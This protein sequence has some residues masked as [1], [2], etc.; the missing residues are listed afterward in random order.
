MVFSKRVSHSSETEENELEDEEDMVRSDIM[1]KQEDED[2]D[3][4]LDL[5]DPTVPT[6]STLRS[7]LNVRK[8][9]CIVCRHMYYIDSYTYVYYFSTHILIFIPP[10]LSSIISVFVRGNITLLQMSKF[11]R[12]S[13]SLILPPH[14][15][16]IRVST[17]FLYNTSLLISTRYWV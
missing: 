1:S 3:A 6:F 4:Q 12:T 9:E 15:E 7:V 14:S 17:H 13:N 16:I 5:D 11:K 8:M 2:E 10:S